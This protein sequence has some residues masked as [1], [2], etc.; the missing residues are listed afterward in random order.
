MWILW[1]V[2]SVVALIIDIIT[3]SFLFVWFCFG[4]V[5]AII[6]ALLKYSVTVQIVSFLAVSALMMAVG[7]PFIRKTLK[8]TVD[9]TLTMEEGYVG[10]RLTANEDITEKTMIKLDGIYWTLKNDGEK[11][12]KG[13]MVEI[14]GIKG[15]KLIVTKIK[16]D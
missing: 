11:I 1:L 9:K 6:A 7:Y 4:G 13:D 2:I 10:R 14:T 3:S 8:K 12:E 5:A 15:N 16:E